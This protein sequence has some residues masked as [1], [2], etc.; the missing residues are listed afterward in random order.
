MTADEAIQR[1][2]VSYLPA[3]Y[4][5][6]LRYLDEEPMDAVNLAFRLGMTLGSCYKLIGV[7][8]ELKVICVHEHIRMSR[9]GECVKI[10]GLGD[11]DAKAP[12]PTTSAQRSASYRARQKQK[13]V[14]LG[15]LGV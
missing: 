10:W 2:A 4:K 3:T 15:M 12:K 14:R 11:K 1:A 9:K 13:P 7:L 6:T 8:K 5:Q